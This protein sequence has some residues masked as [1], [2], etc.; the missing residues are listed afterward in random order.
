MPLIKGKNKNGCWI[1]WGESGKEYYYICN[2]TRS[3]EYSKKKALAQGIAIG[4]LKLDSINDYP[5][6]IQDNATR[7]IELN[8]KNNNKCVTRVGKIRAQQLSN[9]E[10]ISLDTIK[11]MYSY[12]SRA[13]AYYTGADENDCGYISYM[14]WGGP[15]ALVWSK[16]KLDEINLEKI[17]TKSFMN[18]LK[19]IIKKGNT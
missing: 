5:Q 4:D 17:D 15:E 16:N 19:S 8:E 14:L 7:G 18:I 1:K 13:E 3:Y 10:P 2:S 11:R 6:S 12:L 9:G